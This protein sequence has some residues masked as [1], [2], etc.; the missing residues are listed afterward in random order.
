MNSTRVEWHLHSYKKYD[1]QNTFTKF[2]Q[3]TGSCTNAIAI[4][5]KIKIKKT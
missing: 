2:L 5:S 1:S 4:Q 3:F